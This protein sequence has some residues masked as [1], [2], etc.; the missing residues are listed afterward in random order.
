M[1]QVISKDREE[2]GEEI[3]SKVLEKLPKGVFYVGEFALAERLP[4]IYGEYDR[5]IPITVYVVDRYAKQFNV[6]IELSIEIT[7][8]DGDVTESVDEYLQETFEYIESVSVGSYFA[9]SEEYE[10]PVKFSTTVIEKDKAVFCDVST[11]TDHFTKRPILTKITDKISEELIVHEIS[12]T[13]LKQF[14]NST[15]KVIL[16]NINANV[17]ENPKVLNAEN[18]VTRVEY[19][20]DVTHNKRK[21]VFKR[22]ETVYVESPKDLVE[23]ILYLY[24]RN[25]NK[26]L[27]TEDGIASRYVLMSQKGKQEVRNTK[28]INVEENKKQVMRYEAQGNMLSIYLNK[29]ADVGNTNSGYVYMLLQKEK[30]QEHPKYQAIKKRFLEYRKINSDFAKRY[31]EDTDVVQIPLGKEGQ[32]LSISPHY[33]ILTKG[34]EY[35]EIYNLFKGDSL[36]NAKYNARKYDASVYKPIEQVLDVADGRKNV[37]K[38]VKKKQVGQRVF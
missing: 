21:Q 18:S 14:K 17:K 11:F 1:E 38:K 32:T 37:L 28:M 27:Q 24:V 31:Q 29:Y 3:L 15:G 33:A 9:E 34:D 22:Q 19:T 2:L 7:A 25:L 13:L 26:V 35:R 30:Y 4:D 23:D 6:D 12:K 20:F 8:L 36:L 16:E 10:H 5:T